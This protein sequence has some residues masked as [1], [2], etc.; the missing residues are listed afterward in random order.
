MRD[1]FDRPLQE[2]DLV[3]STFKTTSGHIYRVTHIGPEPG[4]ITSW[5]EENDRTERADLVRVRERD[6]QPALR[7]H[8]TFCNGTNIVLLDKKFA[9]AMAQRWAD[10]AKE[11]K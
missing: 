5:S 3:M 4:Y 7:K 11:I 6:L 8:E 10:L 9:T 1:K 2:G